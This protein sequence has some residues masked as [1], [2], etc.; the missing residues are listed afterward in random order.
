ML[1][2]CILTCAG[3]FLIGLMIGMM[4]Q[5]AKGTFLYVG[6]QLTAGGGGR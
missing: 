1:A 3:M 6:S 4:G 2:G 5:P